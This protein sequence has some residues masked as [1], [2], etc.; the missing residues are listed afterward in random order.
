M[1]YCVVV[2]FVYYKCV[3]VEEQPPLSPPNEPDSG[4][5]N[6]TPTGHKS[7]L[8]DDKP[9]AQAGAATSA[10][11]GEKPSKQQSTYC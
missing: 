10:G 5:S 11:K 1:F 6:V 9:S 2:V 8:E 3:R 4:P 7:A